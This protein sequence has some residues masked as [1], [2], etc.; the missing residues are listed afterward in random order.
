MKKPADFAS[1]PEGDNWVVALINQYHLHP[2]VLRLFGPDIQYYTTFAIAQFLRSHIWPAFFQATLAVSRLVD[3]D[4]EAKSLAH[5]GKIGAKTMKVL[6][7][8]EI[9]NPQ[10]SSEEQDAEYWVELA[11]VI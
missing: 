7:I 2:Y 8:L 1:N 4:P 5:I 10:R 6:H 9:M 11:K 3:V